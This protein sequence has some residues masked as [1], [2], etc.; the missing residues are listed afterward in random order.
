M[1][2]FYP[3]TYT[4]ERGVENTVIENDGETLRVT[5]RG[6]TFM[7]PDFDR[8]APSEESTPEQL[9]YFSLGPDSLCA[10]RIIFMM[11]ISIYNCG[12][13][14]EGSLKIEVRIDD[15]NSN[16][17]LEYYQTRIRLDCDQGE[18]TSSGK[19]R[20]FES[21][22]LEIQSLLPAG[23]YMRLCINCLFSDYSP[24]GKSQFGD[25]MCYRNKKADYLKVK[26]KVDYFSLGF[27]CDRKVQETYLCPEFER[28]VPGTGY[29]I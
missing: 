22:L 19:G 8:L 14:S 17:A 3:A 20:D 1:K 6:V 28:R 21:E 23:F 7:G 12:D 9:G 5:I 29:R 4:D 24:F 18:F 25:L 10:C 15:P 27:V 26:N 11:P 13:N 16:D 2:D